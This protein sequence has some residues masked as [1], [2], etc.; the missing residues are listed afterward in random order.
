MRHYSIV[1]PMTGQR[2]GFEAT[3]ASVLRSAPAGTQ[4]IVPHVDR[5]DDPWR[6]SGE[7]EFLQLSGFDRADLSG[8]LLKALARA[9]NEL[10]GIVLPGLELG[11]DWPVKISRQFDDPV[12]ASVGTSLRSPGCG[13]PQSG[14]LEIG[15]SGRIRF[16]RPNDGNRPSDSCTT[17]PG[18]GA[19]FY[20]NEALG[21]LPAD[22]LGISPD[23]LALE[24][25]LGL[26]VL[27]YES[28][29][30]PVS[31]TCPGKPAD[32]RPESQLPASVV[33]RLLVRAGK[34]NG[35]FARA[36]GDLLQGC[37]QRAVTRLLAIRL[38][39][40]DRIFSSQLHR[41]RD[42]RLRVETI[43]LPDGRAPQS[44]LQRAA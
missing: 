23:S 35:I 44:G 15:A 3:L 12:V 28:R 24:L 36:L 31:V 22:G 25:L 42:A 20:R 2:A 32:W 7:V 6:V 11:D 16:G 19:A 8:L 27:G 33:E 10:V 9:G 5:Y 30:A 41:A 43:R 21:W 40:A 38:R 37:P 39:S 13:S 18:M 29:L 14:Q 17:G 4:V 26:K 34:G 1:V